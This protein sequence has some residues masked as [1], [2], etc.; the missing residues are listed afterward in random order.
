MY[1]INL[2]VYL[3]YKSGDYLI[4]SNISDIWSH[5]YNKVYLV[6]SRST[7]DYK[8]IGYSKKTLFL[9]KLS[10][11]KQLNLW[12]SHERQVESHYSQFG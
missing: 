11:V 4:E 3:L 10:Q 12:I 1:I 7:L 2:K 6:N 5:I 8:H 9:F